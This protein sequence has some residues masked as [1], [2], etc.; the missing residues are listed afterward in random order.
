MNSARHLLGPNYYLEFKSH[1]QLEIPVKHLS[2]TFHDCISIHSGITVVA[3]QNLW[4]ELSVKHLPAT[5]PALPALSFV[6]LLILVVGIKY[7]TL[8][9]VALNHTVTRGCR[10]RSANR[11]NRPAL[12]QL[13]ELS[14]WD[15][16]SV[17]HA[18]NIQL[19]LIYLF[20]FDE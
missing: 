3:A 15:S 16:S 13:T 11:V 10:Q 19:S 5:L 8:F 4:L 17:S 14:S 12:T 1:L 6:A 18:S 20:C 7:T 9:Q 2:A